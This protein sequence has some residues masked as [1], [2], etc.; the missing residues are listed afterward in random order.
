MAVTFISHS[1]LLP[2]LVMK[3]IISWLYAKL[4]NCSAYSAIFMPYKLKK[5]TTEVVAQFLLVIN[6]RQNLFSQ[7]WRSIFQC[8]RYL[9][10]I[11]LQI[12]IAR[13]YLYNL[14]QKADIFLIFI[15]LLSSFSNEFFP[16]CF[17][18]EPATKFFKLCGTVRVNHLYKNLRIYSFNS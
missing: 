2:R 18:R 4:N 5:A 1:S 6:L 17:R 3:S 13:L 12:Y 16:G 14:L 11:Q 15:K 9:G 8:F 7:L 10:Q